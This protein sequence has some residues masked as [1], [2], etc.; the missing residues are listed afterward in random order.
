[1]VFSGPIQPPMLGAALASAKLHLSAGFELLQAEHHERLQAA[2]EAIVRH[3]LRLA[4]D[5][6]TPICM[7]QF[8]SAE[9]ARRAVGEIFERGYY[10][11]YAAFP[12]VPMDRPSLRFTLSRHNDVAEIKRFIE[13]LADVVEHSSES[14]AV[15]VAV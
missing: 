6:W 14:T 5:D 4:T 8:D 12:A 13:T 11:C 1:M 7:V 9:R 15:A 3:R 10:C 2:R